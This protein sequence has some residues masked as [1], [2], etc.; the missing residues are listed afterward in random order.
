MFLDDQTQQVGMARTQVANLLKSEDV[1]HTITLLDKNN[2]N[3][4]W[5]QKEL[6]L[7]HQRLGHAGFRWIQNPMLKPK[8]DE[9]DNE[10][11]PV[12]PVKNSGTHHCEAPWCPACQLSKAHRWTWGSSRVHQKP[13]L[14]M[15]SILV[16]QYQAQT[17]GGQPH[18][19]GHEPKTE[20]YVGGT[21]CVN[22]SS[23][24][25]FHHHQTLLQAGTMI[26]GKHKFETFADQFGI[27]LKTFHAHNHPF[28][29]KEFL[30][31]VELQD[32]EI[33]FS[34]VGNHHQNGVSE[35]A[36]QTLT[37]WAL[38][39]MTHQLMHW[40]ACFQADMWSFAFDH[41]V[42]IWNH[43]PQA[44][45]GLCPLELFTRTKSSRHDTITN[46]HVWGCPAYV[47]NPKLQTARVITGHVPWPF[48]GTFSYG[49]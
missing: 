36:T 1:K 45:S 28:A 18:T 34:G 15:A 25:I 33:K 10:E 13:E 7:W 40:P 49:W 47:L 26:Q 38:C 9:G 8:V 32:Q 29:K 14:E 19:H 3:L 35:W 23:G 48:L 22:Y 24:C 37:S 27:K 41:A 11:P 6:M 43:L 17:L 16:D 21:I 12:I 44:W 5:Q 42:M 20:Q 30:K 4:S 39:Y 46:A 2:H 31:D